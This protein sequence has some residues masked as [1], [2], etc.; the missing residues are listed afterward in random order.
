MKNNKNINVA[1][2]RQNQTEVQ[3]ENSLTNKC[4]TIKNTTTQ[5]NQVEPKK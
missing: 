2:D 1:N 5:I 4:E 3:I